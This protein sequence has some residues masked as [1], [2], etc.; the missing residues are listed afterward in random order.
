MSAARWLAF[1]I[2]IA[3]VAAVASVINEFVLPVIEIANSQSTTQESAQGIE[4][5]STGWEWMPLSILLLFVF[6]LIVGVIVRRQRTT[7]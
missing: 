6:T 2:G 7:I 3:V 5:Y 4:W 1:T